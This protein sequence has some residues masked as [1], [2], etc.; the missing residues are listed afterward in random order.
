[1]GGLHAAVRTRPTHP[2]L[3]WGAGNQVGT[4]LTSLAATETAPNGGLSY[5]GDL[6]TAGFRIA[7]MAAGRAQTL[8]LGDLKAARE[9]Y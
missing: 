7:R 4:R 2:T 1:M 8:R 5:F 6:D 9:L 3:V